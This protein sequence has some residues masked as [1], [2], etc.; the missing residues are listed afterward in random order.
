L[1]QQLNS[2]DVD[3]AASGWGGDRYAVYWREESDD[4]VLVLR[5]AWDSNTDADQFTAAYT[6]YTDAHYGPIGQAQADGGTC[7]HSSVATCIYAAGAEVLVVRAPD[8]DTAVTLA[9]VIYEG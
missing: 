4:L 1:I 5:T 2:S 8:L 3:T 6:R 7:W 9:A